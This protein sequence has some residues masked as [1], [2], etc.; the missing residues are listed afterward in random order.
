MVKFVKTSQADRKAIASTT[1]LSNKTGKWWNDPGLRTLNFLL[2]IPLIS[3]YVQGYDASLINNGSS[4]PWSI[5]ELG[6]DKKCSSKSC[7]LAG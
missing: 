6:T 5:L 2:F 1:P 3:E 7:G 4:V